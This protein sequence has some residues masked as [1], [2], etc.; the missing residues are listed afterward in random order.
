MLEMKKTLLRTL[1]AALI[2]CAASCGEEAT[3]TPGFADSTLRFVP[4]KPT[5]LKLRRRLCC[6]A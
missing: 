2:L 3:P 6:N 1:G 5:I 4:G